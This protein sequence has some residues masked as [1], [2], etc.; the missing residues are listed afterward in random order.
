MGVNRVVSIEIGLIY[1]K[2]CEVN[3]RKK[4]TKVRKAFVFETPEDTI[5]DGYIRDKTTFANELKRQLEEHKIKNRNVLFTIA[6]NKILSREVTIPQVKEKRIMDIVRAE[7]NEYF[8]MD[9]TEHVL[10]Y[11]L[12]GPGAEPKQLRLLVFAAPLT[13]IKNYYNLAELLGVT[14]VALDYIGNSSYQILKRIPGDDV[15]FVIQL[16][17]QNSLVSILQGGDL[18]MQRNVNFG[19]ATLV[20]VMRGF[21]EFGGKNGNQCYDYLC[22]NALLRRHLERDGGYNAGERPPEEE[23]AQREE[24]TDELMEELRL[25]VS[26]IGRVIEYYNTREPNRKIGKLY[27]LGKGTKILGLKELLANETNFEVELLEGFRSISFQKQKRGQAELEQH[28][29]ELF[30]CV[31]AAL[32]PVNFIPEE[33]RLKTERRLG[34]RLY[35]LLFILVTLSSGTMLWYAYSDYQE[36]LDKKDELTKRRDSS[37]YIEPIF[38]AWSRSQNAKE[39]AERL[40]GMT[41]SYNDLLLQM[42]GE[43]EEKLPANSIVQSLSATDSGM[44][45]SFV[46]DSKETAAALLTSLKQIPYVGGTSIAGITES[47]GEED[48]KTTVTFSVSITWTLPEEVTGNE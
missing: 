34:M 6:S 32:N 11:T 9:I 33:L 1:T 37:L 10:T 3:Y 39:E 15:N 42:I 4:N 5:E 38:D 13:L 17:Q 45:I 16:N 7:A 24:M 36:E 8:P 29:D 41:F 18:L 27:L 25:F 43:L 46:T 23:R 48:G 22:E 20:D 35:I 44:F 26:N 31:G 14:L 30:S 12:L 40:V 28:K 19:V 47:S 2:V 21:Q